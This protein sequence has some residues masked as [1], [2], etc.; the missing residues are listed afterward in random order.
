MNTNIGDKYIL[1][2]LASIAVIILI[3]TVGSFNTE[4][5]NGNGMTEMEGIISS[6]SL[7][8]NGTVFILTDLDGNE[9]RCFYRSAMPPTPALCK[10]VGSFSADGNMFFVDRIMI[11]GM[12]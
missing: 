9:Y 3:C 4:T 1:F 7:S 12:Q 8:Q 10:L 2:S 6:P 5:V 11:N